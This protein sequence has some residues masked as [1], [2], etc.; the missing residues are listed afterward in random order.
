MIFSY[1]FDLVLSY[2]RSNG[3]LSHYQQNNSNNIWHDDE[4]MREMRWEDLNSIMCHRI[5][6]G[7]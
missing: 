5:R 3:G 6:G 2:F 4:N 1:Y 7:K